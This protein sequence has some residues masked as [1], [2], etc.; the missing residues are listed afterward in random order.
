MNTRYFLQVFNTK[1][2]KSE[3][4][5]TQLVI[6]EPLTYFSADASSLELG[7]FTALP[8]API[9]D[10]DGDLKVHLFPEGKN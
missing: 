3:Q 9:A 4:R 8:K 2:T 10:F 7:E 1:K 6:D 5:Q